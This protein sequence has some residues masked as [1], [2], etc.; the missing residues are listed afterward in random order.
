MVANTLFS[1]DFGPLVHTTHDLAT[2]GLCGV[3]KL[4]RLGFWG[5][6][7]PRVYDAIAWCTDSGVPL[8]PPFREGQ[9]ISLALDTAINAVLDEWLA[10]P[11]ATPDLLTA[12][13]GAD[14]GTWPRTRVRDEALTFMFAGHET[15]ANA[16]SWFWYLLGTQRRRPRPHARRDRRFTRR[17]PSDRR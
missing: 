17:P 3:E 12:L 2:R 4:Q 6:M 14:G 15:T 16:M 5:L 7:P 9:R 10:H 13:F 11:P 8:P 1:Q